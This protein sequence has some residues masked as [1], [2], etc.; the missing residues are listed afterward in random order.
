[1]VQAP[2]SFLIQ[3]T[4]L[5]PL[6]TGS[7]ELVLILTPSRQE[8]DQGREAEGPRATPPARNHPCEGGEVDHA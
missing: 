2:L 7:Y 6:S 1:M 3:A 8:R 5:T 4:R